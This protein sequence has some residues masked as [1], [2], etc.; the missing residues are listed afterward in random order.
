M[1]NTLTN[2][3]IPEISIDEAQRL[4]KSGKMSNKDWNAF[5]HAWQNGANRLIIRACDCLECIVKY[6]DLFPLTPQ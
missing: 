6:P 1:A 3:F 5:A 4:R 2:L